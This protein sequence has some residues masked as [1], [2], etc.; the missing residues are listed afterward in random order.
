LCNEIH[1]LRHLIIVNV[2]TIIYG[3]CIDIFITIA[4]Y[5]FA[6]KFKYELNS[7][8]YKKMKKIKSLTL[9]AIMVAFSLFTVGIASAELILNVQGNSNA[10]GSINAHNP[11][12]VEIANTGT[13][14][15]NVSLSFENIQ[16]S[17]S[18]DIKVTLNDGTPVYENN[19]AQI[20]ELEGESQKT[21]IVSVNSINPTIATKFGD[22]RTAKMTATAGEIVSNEATLSYF[23]R[24]CRS[25]AARQ[26]I[27]EIRKAKIKNVG[28]SEGDNDEWF[29][30]DDIEVTVKVDNNGD[31]DNSSDDLNDLT[32]EI[33]FLDSSGRN[34]INDFEFDNSDEESEDIGDLDPDDDDKVVFRFRLEEPDKDLE[35]NFDFVVKVFERGNEDNV[36][37]D[38]SDDLDDDNGFSERIDLQRENDEEKF[39]RF[40]DIRIV[41]SQATCNELIT[42]DADAVNIGNDD[43]TILTVY[44]TNTALDLDVDQRV[45]DVDEG[46]SSSVTFS[47]L[48]PEGVANGNYNLILSSEYEVD[49]DPEIGEEDEVV[50]LTVL[51]C[52][53]GMVDEPS[54]QDVAISA[55]LTSG[56]EAGQ[57]LVVDA[58]ITNTGT[59]GIFKVLATGFDSWATLES[60][61]PGVLSLDLGESRT[62][63]ITMIVNEDAVGPQL[64][65]L[66]VR[67]VNTDQLIDVRE[68]EVNIGGEAP[69]VTGGFTGFADRANLV[70]VIAIVNIILIVLIILVAIRL[71]RRQ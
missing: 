67:D 31:E 24:F 2:I 64:F 11:V 7:Q 47:F 30:F 45:G 55:D 65:T 61:S 43:V 36:C 41:P 22:I 25:G 21:L 35:G 58:I 12:N 38:F 20:F 17:N 68:V 9:F 42:I 48:V 51:G 46:E 44:L 4:E 57:E 32:I 18:G 3:N 26:D 10:L 37:V 52:G 62:A 1:P 71:S 8:D 50:K 15:V 28:D 66:E 34:F 6:K 70:W 40:N 60:I 56:G 53:I 19:Q 16:F 14:T 23:Q 49:D 59:S 13:L 29:P 27:L 54:V 63:T 5:K 69:A 33:G 39:I